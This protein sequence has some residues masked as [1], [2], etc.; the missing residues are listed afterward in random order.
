MLFDVS[1]DPHLLN[2]QAPSFPDITVGAARRLADWREE[3]LVDTPGGID[4]HDVVL[5]EGRPFHIWGEL[6][7]YIDRL[8][9]TGRGPIADELTARYPE[10]AAGKGPIQPWF[11]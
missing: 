9:A 7:T 5:S 1:S 11:Y 6:P 3:M 10:A 4:S 2:D 8:R